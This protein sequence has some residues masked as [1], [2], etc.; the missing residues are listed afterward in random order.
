ML[1]GYKIF[2]LMLMVAGVACNEK[3]GVS[4]GL[5]RA[6]PW[7]MPLSNTS[8]YLPVIIAGKAT[9][10]QLGDLAGYVGHPAGQPL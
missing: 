10:H 2:A 4:W 8:A 9:A 1:H 3:E 7:P 5:L 6:L